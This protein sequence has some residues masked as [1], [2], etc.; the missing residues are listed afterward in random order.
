MKMM[1][2]DA[3]SQ[4]KKDSTEDNYQIFGK[5]LLEYIRRTVNSFKRRCS[6]EEL[7]DIIG[8]TLIRV[9][10]KLPTFRGESVFTTWVTSVME[11]QGKELIRSETKKA[12]MPLFDNDARY[13]PSLSMSHKLILERLI[14]QLDLYDKLFTHLKLRGYTNMEVAEKLNIPI[15]TANWQWKEIQAKLRTQRGGII[16]P[17]APVCVPEAS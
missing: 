6:N 7:D 2:N 11:S 10:E 13:D 1:L 14:D 4:Y 17:E 15:G 12:A 8:D 9:L 3:Y 16:A 5:A